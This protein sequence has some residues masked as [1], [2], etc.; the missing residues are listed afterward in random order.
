MYIKVVTME[1]GRRGRRG[2]AKR[3]V[4]YPQATTLG[5][6]GDTTM[7]PHLH[8]KYTDS[9]FGFFRFAPRHRVP[10]QEPGPMVCHLPSASSTL[11]IPRHLMSP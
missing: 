2:L 5:S 4:L 3:G 1:M 10:V 8:F 9:V 7:E 11:I 6:K